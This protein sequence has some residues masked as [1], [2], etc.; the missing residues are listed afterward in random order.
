MKRVYYLPLSS[1]HPTERTPESFQEAER[2]WGDQED[3]QTIKSL[4]EALRTKRPVPPIVV[5]RIKR[6]NYAIRNG[7]HRYAAA[8]WIGLKK[9]PAI[10]SDYVHDPDGNKPIKWEKTA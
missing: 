8:T 4:K 5:E 10:I 7:H 3:M 1:V 2:K 6:G 9:I